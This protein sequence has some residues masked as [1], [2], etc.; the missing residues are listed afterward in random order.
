VLVKNNYYNMKHLKSKRIFESN[1]L[2]TE[3]EKKF[4]TELVIHA[5]S[6]REF[7]S[8]EHKI[9]RSIFHKLGIGPLSYDIG[10][11]EWENYS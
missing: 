1:E 7:N 5:S 10:S 9:R 4:I 6:T 8:R 11:E 2:L 3:E